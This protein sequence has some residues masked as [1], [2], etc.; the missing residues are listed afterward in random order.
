MEV[1]AISTSKKAAVV[2]ASVVFVVLSA[3]QVHARREDWPLSKYDMYSLKHGAYAQRK[4][5]YGVSPSGEF[6][7]ASAGYRVGSKFWFQFSNIEKEKA[8]VRD[9]LA[10]VAED[11]EQR[12]ADNPEL[13]A[14]SGIKV[15]KESWK[16]A[17]RMEG[18]DRIERKVL[19]EFT[20][21]ETA[22]SQARSKPKTSR[23]PK[24]PSPT[25]TP[26]SAEGTQR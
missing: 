11:Y 4:V 16:I 12:R 8:K 5:L 7:L 25:A 18:V 3:W 17:P 26:P 15:Y 22:P 21:H 20:A 14:L 6:N 2:A 24:P 23:H 19:S 10:K 1:G 13:P 9:L